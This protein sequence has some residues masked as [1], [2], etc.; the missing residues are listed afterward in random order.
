MEEKLVLIETVL[1]EYQ[2]QGTAQNVRRMLLSIN[3]YIQSQLGDVSPDHN[4]S[5][6]TLNTA[7]LTTE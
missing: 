4:I 3:Q 6:L 7:P 1:E 2:K 5:R